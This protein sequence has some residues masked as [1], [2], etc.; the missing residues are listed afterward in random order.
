ME[1]IVSRRSFYH[2]SK[3]KTIIDIGVLQEC[4]ILGCQFLYGTKNRGEGNSLKTWD[5]VVFA[6]MAAELLCWQN[7][8][9]N[10]APSVNRTGS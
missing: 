10:S 3:V 5:Q 9:V 4:R 8:M 6:P 2:R 7:R 1:P